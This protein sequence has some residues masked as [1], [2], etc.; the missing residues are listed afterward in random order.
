MKFIFAGASTDDCLLAI[1]EICA[2]RPE[3]FCPPALNLVVDQ[4]SALSNF[5]TA[6]IFLL[7]Y[8]INKEDCYSI[9]RQ[10]ISKVLM[11]KIP[12]GCHKTIE[13]SYQNYMFYP[14]LYQLFPEAE[15]IFFLRDGRDVVASELNS[16]NELNPEAIKT[17]EVRD[18]AIK[19]LNSIGTG[20]NGIVEIKSLGASTN[21]IKYEDLCN[22]SLNKS[23][24]SSISNSKENIAVDLNFKQHTN[25]WRT[26]FNQEH[27]KVLK[28]ELDETLEQMGYLKNSPW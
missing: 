21:V 11:S 2:S 19:W 14:R 18:C 15:F 3:I 22:P 12:V 8:G 26:V 6:E 24:I 25:Q 7:E 17:E 1:R 5:E 13:T 20:L 4:L 9:F 23:I 16:K 10:L 27:I 28:D